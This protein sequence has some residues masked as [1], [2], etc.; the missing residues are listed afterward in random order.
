MVLGKTAEYYVAYFLIKLGHNTSVVNHDGID[1]ITVIEN[2]PIRIEVKSS[3]TQ[4]KNRNGKQTIVT[5]KAH[6]NNKTHKRN[7]K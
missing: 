4:I 1:L 6:R 2:R 7:T 3:Q 5:K